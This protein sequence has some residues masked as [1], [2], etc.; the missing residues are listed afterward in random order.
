MIKICEYCGKEF[1]TDRE[2]KR[3]C[4]RQCKQKN[5]QS[6]KSKGIRL[7]NIEYTKVC[8]VCNTEFVTVHQ[9]KKYCSKKCKNK[10]MYQKNKGKYTYVSTKVYHYTYNLICKTCGKPFEASAKNTKYCLECRQEGRYTHVCKKCGK[11][12]VGKN[13]ICDECKVKEKEAKKIRYTKECVVCGKSFEASNKYSKYCSRDC[14]KVVKNKRAKVYRDDPSSNYKQTQKKWRKKWEDTPEGKLRAC[15]GATLRRCVNS[16]HN[17]S[18]T[19]VFGYTYRELREHL[20]KQ[21]TEDMNWD[22]YGYI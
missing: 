7:D 17:L 15:M 22:N 10:A 19:T 21:F 18:V 12:F 20:Q 9:D 8:P 1:E 11:T 3:F 16:N 13:H 4:C 2:T 5:K 6:R 14:E